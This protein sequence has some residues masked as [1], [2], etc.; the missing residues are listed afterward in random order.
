[1]N[2]ASEI[3]EQYEAGNFNDEKLTGH[4]G[5]TAF[6]SRILRIIKFFLGKNRVKA[7]SI[8]KQAAKGDCSKKA[9]STVINAERSRRA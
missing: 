6:V 7:D 5:K 3:A 4:G 9:V 1:M 8:H 2:S